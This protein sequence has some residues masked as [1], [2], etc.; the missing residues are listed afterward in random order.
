MERSDTPTETELGLQR[1]A[2]EFLDIWEKVDTGH[3]LTSLSL[4][5]QCRDF[6]EKGWVELQLYP[7]IGTYTIEGK[8]GGTLLRVPSAQIIF[9][10]QGLPL[11]H[12]IAS[13]Y[14]GRYDAVHLQIHKIIAEY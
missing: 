9:T 8:W 12:A 14:S 6:I 5:P 7:R 13:V 11:A 4:I 1:Q 10:E 2:V 3:E